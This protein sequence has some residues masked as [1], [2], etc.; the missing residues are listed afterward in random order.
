M[1]KVRTAAVEFQWVGKL[2]DFVSKDGDKI[3][4]LRLAVAER[5]YWIE[6]PKPLRTAL[7]PEI[8]P[9]SQLAVSGWASRC[10]KTGKLALVA[11]SIRLAAKVGAS[12]GES[13]PPATSLLP[14]PTKILVCTQA[15]YCKRGA[16]AVRTILQAHLQARGLA[17]RVEIRPI[18]CLKACKDGPN[19]VV[20]PGGARY[21]QIGPG[22]VAAL[23]AEHFGA[24]GAPQ[25]AAQSSFQD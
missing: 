6:V 1:G 20:M 24:D 21:G 4:Y 5:E 7:S 9:G 12:E 18:G 22:R 16:A 19:L 15:G 11:E 17:E 13:A 23:M 25:V 3:E 2:R 10:G 8:G 14:Q